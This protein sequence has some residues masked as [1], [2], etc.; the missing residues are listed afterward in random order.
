MSQDEENT[1]S[2]KEHL[3]VLVRERFELLKIMIKLKTESIE[4]ATDLAKKE[5][6]LRLEGMNE[7]RDTLKDQASRFIT[8]DE[9]NA[10]LEKY[11]GE[12]KSLRDS[13]SSAEGKDTQK[14]TIVGWNLQLGTLIFSMLA[15]VVALIAYFK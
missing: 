15:L 11:G 9:Y 8:R 10:L 5:V 12:I 14:S 3:E 4:R 1:V 7:F 2:L 13:R 6:D